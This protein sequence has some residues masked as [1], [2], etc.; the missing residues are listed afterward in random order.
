VAAVLE[1]Q[2]RE[3]PAADL[4]ASAERAV[5]ERLRSG[6]RSLDRALA[7]AGAAVIAECK[8]ASPSAGVLREPFDPVG[9]ARAYQA[10]G[11]A[12]ISVV[13]EPDF[14]GGDPAWLPAVREAV[15][16]PVLRK[17][18]VV[19]ERQM[20]ETA[21]S[22][23]DAVLLIQR[24]L[25]A[26]DLAALLQLATTLELDVLL[27]V[28]ADE[29]PRPAV[30]S[31]ARIIGVNARDL[32]TFVTDLGRV[33]ELAEQIPSDRIKVAESGISSRLDLLRLT[34]VG[35][36]AFLVGEHL[37]RSVDPAATL[38]ELLRTDR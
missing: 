25:D 11:A 12:A 38:R 9:L 24:L 21:A 31:G 29:D 1:R 32:A 3:E 2:R 8:H 13:T 10:A 30:D 17:D 5:E 34:D 4:V 27:E 37:V 7:G 19:T 6:P 28:F 15:D 22:G 33:G 23:A 20:L 26:G 16:L 18:F 36:D 14:F 35:Y